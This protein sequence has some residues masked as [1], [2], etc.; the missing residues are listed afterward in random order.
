MGRVPVGFGSRL[1]VVEVAEVPGVEEEVCPEQVPKAPLPRSEGERGVEVQPPRPIRLPAQV[2]PWNTRDPHST[3]R[4]R[5]P[6]LLTEDRM[7][8][9]RPIGGADK[10]PCDPSAVSI[11]TVYDGDRNW[12]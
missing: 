11:E 9:R 7:R 8:N 12:S 6:R 10:L 1:T 4:V 3:V 5:T 2:V